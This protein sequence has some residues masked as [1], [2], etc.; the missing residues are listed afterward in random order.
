MVYFQLL[1]RGLSK[2]HKYLLKD[3]NSV[4]KDTPKYLNQFD[5][6][7]TVQCKNYYDKIGSKKCWHHACSEFLIISANT[8]HYVMVYTLLESYDAQLSDKHKY[9]SYRQISSEICIN[10]SKG[11]NDVN[12]FLSYCIL[13]YFFF[14]VG[15]RAQ[16]TWKCL[17]TAFF[18][19]Y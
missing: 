19:L 16:F 10:L 4:Y 5:W 9:I 8:S 14:W 17:I 6:E 15:Y 13:E 7:L 3:S 11:R 18:Y 12:I 1:D 2:W